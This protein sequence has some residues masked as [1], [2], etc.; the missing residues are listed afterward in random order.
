MKVAFFKISF[1]L[2]PSLFGARQ[3]WQRQ[4]IQV[5]GVLTQYPSL[6]IASQMILAALILQLTISLFGGV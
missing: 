3:N 4:Q 5:Q 1:P 2:N 6:T